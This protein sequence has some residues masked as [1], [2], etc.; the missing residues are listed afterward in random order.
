MAAEWPRI[1]TPQLARLFACERSLT[2]RHRLDDHPKCVSPQDLERAS[3]RAATAIFVSAPAECGYT[4]VSGP[5]RFPLTV[6]SFY[7]AA[8]ST[9][10]AAARS[11]LPGFTVPGLCCRR[12]RLSPRPGV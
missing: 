5:R 4:F 2:Q 7:L 3:G 1:S 12:S 6:C 9:I 11:G 10:S 8:E